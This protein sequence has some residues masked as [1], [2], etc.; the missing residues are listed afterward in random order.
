MICLSGKMK[1]R[2]HELCIYTLGLKIFCFCEISYSSS[3]HG[4][5]PRWGESG[6]DT[7]PTSIY[8]IG[9]W[10][11]QEFRHTDEAVNMKTS[12]QRK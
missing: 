4:L 12:S 1:A 7:F 3:L 2:A 11:L 6:R 10:T 5:S 8:Q 9:Y